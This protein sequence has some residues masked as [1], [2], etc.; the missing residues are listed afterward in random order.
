MSEHGSQSKDP[1]WIPVSAADTAAV[2]PN[3]MSTFFA[4]SVSSFFINNKP[5]FING[6]RILPQNSHEC[7]ISDR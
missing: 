4:N 5:A 6:L 7:G 2:N 3:V 1:L